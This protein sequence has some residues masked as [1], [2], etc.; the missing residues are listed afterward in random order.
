MGKTKLAVV[1]CG[2]W[3]SY[4]THAWEEVDIVALCDPNIALA[5]QLAGLLGV[6]KIYPDLQNMLDSESVDLVDIITDVDSHAP[7]VKI[8]ADRNLPVICQ[9]P[10]GPSYAVAADMVRYCKEKNTPFFIHENFR[11]QNPI[12]MVKKLLD[13]NP[14]GKPFKANLKFCSSFPVFDN[15]P[16][17]AELDQFILTDVGTHLLDMSRFL[18]GEVTSLYSQI[19]RVNPIIK[20]E[21]VANVFLRHKNDVH[22]YVEM[23][24]ASRLHNESFPETFILIEGEKG[25]IYLGPKHQLSCT[26]LVGTTHFDAT[27]KL[28]DWS[29]PDYAL[30]HSSIVACNQNIMNA[31]RKSGNAETTGEDNLKTIKLVFDAYESARTNKVIVYD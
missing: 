12:R 1:G 30:I 23:S 24:Y 16:F 10:M 27:P 19:H 29:L 17:L 20:G 8:C 11:W 9:K 31:I 3:S 18:F 6:K 14:I 2:F 5:D 26:T 15:Q 28:Y 13:E 25:S 4:Q 21:D 22:S 7:L